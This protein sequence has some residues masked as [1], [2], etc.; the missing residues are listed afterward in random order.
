MTSVE[1]IILGKNLARG[2][3]NL[4]QVHGFLTVWLLRVSELQ[5]DFILRANADEMPMRPCSTPRGESR[6]SKK[7]CRCSIRKGCGFKKLASSLEGMVV[8]VLVNLLTLNPRE[9]WA[10]YPS[11]SSLSMIL[12]FLI[13]N[14]LGRFHCAF[15]EKYK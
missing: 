3:N 7:E 15:S 11:E 1:S 5:M 12:S 10:V 9:K 14:D 2:Q 8:R 6:L 4:F 13:S